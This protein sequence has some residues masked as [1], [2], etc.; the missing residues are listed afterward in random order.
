MCLNRQFEL[1]T[2]AQISLNLKAFHSILLSFTCEFV[3]KTQ[4]ERLP[5]LMNV[6]REIKKAID[7]IA[8]M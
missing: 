8:T 5:E 1:P 7:E 4:K 3:E 6:N 2:Y